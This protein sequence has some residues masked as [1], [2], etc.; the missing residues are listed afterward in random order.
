MSIRPAL[1][2]EAAREA[3]TR[4]LEDRVPMVKQ[5]AGAALARLDE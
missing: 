5:K 3:L 4:A 1:E 2:A